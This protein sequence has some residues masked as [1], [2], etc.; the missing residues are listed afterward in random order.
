MLSDKA[1]M[2]VANIQ[3]KVT[4]KNTGKELPITDTQVNLAIAAINLDVEQKKLN[5]PET[6]L[7]I[8]ANGQTDFILK[9]TEQTITLKNLDADLSKLI[10]NIEQIAV[11][12][13]SALP[14]LAEQAIDNKIQLGL[15]A[16]LEQQTVDI[17]NLSMNSLNANISGSAN[18]KQLDTNPIINANLQLAETNPTELLKALRIALPDFAGESVLQ[19]LALQT[20]VEFNTKNSEVKVSKLT[21]QFDKTTFNAKVSSFKPEPMSANF[22][23]AIGTIKVDDYLPKTEEQAAEPETTETVKIELPKEL[24]RSLNLS[25]SIKVE[26]VQFQKI[27]AQNTA[28]KITAKNGLVKITPI[29]TTL[30]E[31][32]LKASAV[33]DVTTD[34]QKFALT[35]DGSQ[36]P[37]GELSELFME[38]A[39][40]TG[41]GT[42]AVDITTQGETIDA[43]KQNLNGTVAAN[44]KDGAVKGFNLAQMIREAKAKISSQTLPAEEVVQQTDFSALDAKTSIKQGIVTI[45]QLSALSPYLR[46]TGAGTVDLV[47]EQL[48]NKVTAKIVASNEGQGGK[49]LSDLSGLPIPVTI[50]G[51]WL[52]PKIGLDM[53]S[54]LD[55]KTK[56]KLDEEKAK[57]KEKL[58]AEKAKIAEDAKKKLE[59]AAGDKVKNLFNG[60][61]F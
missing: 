5:I 58:D 55:A 27:N 31:R 42:V 9:Q 56:Q 46:V 44:L 13:A 38:K 24:I 34:E 51:H 61:K 11:N 43:F 48:D 53:K 60:L 47:K 33:V 23:L 40:L 29:T 50:K 15:N 8:N 32:P 35:F 41:K 6:Q 39:P 20:A 17:K 49:D 26:G 4:L 12:G 1:A 18:V 10:F 36:I 19:S 14:S 21:G 16:N 28:L 25:G 59:D 30:L 37:V 45:D 3:S 52:D 57:L 7:S 2:S 22:D 54:L